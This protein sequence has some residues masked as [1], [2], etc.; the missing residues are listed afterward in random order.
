MNRRILAIIIFLMGFVLVVLLFI[1]VYWI[2][3]ALMLREAAFT[4]GVEEAVSNVVL[5][6]ERIESG[7]R[8]RSFKESAR[9]YRKIDSLNYLIDKRY[10]E[11]TGEDGSSAA[12]VKARR[13]I[14]QDRK[15]WRTLRDLDTTSEFRENRNIQEELDS[16]I[17]PKQIQTIQTR[18]VNIEDDPVYKRLQ[19]QRESVVEELMSRSLIYDAALGRFDDIIEMPLEKRIQPGIVDSML[20]V[21][22]QNKGIKTEFEFGI[23]DTRRDS[24]IYQKTGKFTQELLNKA[25]AVNLF[26]RQPGKDKAI[27]LVYFPYERQYMVQQIWWLLLLSILLVGTFI[28]IFYKTISTILYQKKLSDMK[29][30][31]ISN[32]THEFKTPV[33]TISLACEALNDPDVVKTPAMSSNYIQIITDENRRL[34][35]MAEKIL[36]ASVLKQG[37]LELNMVPCAMHEIITECVQKVGI[38]AETAGGSIQTSLQAL[39][40]MV[41]GDRLHLTSVVVNLLDNAIKYSPIRPTIR[42]NTYNRDQNFV[43]EVIDNGIGISKENQGMIFDKLYR[44]PTGNIHNVK[45]FGLGLSYTKAIVEAHQGNISVSSELKKG[46]TFTVT[47]PNFEP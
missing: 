21:E 10:H 39:H 1:Q 8:L 43:F 15:S 11:L 44:V 26:P 33:S 42:I 14:I 29:N 2:R 32:I 34:G 30:D 40:D 36:I 46:T 38:Q 25:F 12:D 45:G 7:K 6:L 16:L 24:L 28:A 18:S 47:L 5:S 13:K 20:A 35:T 9:L 31:F 37:K 23:Y 41:R 27:L 4:A 22:L 19:K 17:E 3:N